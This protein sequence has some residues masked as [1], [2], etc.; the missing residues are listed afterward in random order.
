MGEMETVTGVAAA[1]ML[2][3]A[4]A[5]FVPSET[6]TALTVALLP[7]GTLDGALYTPV[8]EMLP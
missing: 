2:T 6:L 1:T 8:E 7:L 5:D 3:A 4:E